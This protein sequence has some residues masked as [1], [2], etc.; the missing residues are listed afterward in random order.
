[1]VPGYILLTGAP[2]GKFLL[3]LKSSANSRF[4]EWG[5]AEAASKPV[6][7]GTKPERP[8]SVLG[9]RRHTCGSTCY[10]MG[11]KDGVQ[12][13]GYLKVFETKDLPG[14]P[15]LSPGHGHL[16]S[17]WYCLAE[18][19]VVIVY[20]S[21]T[22]FPP[23]VCIFV[24]TGAQACGCMSLHRHID[25]SK[26][27]QVDWSV[28]TRDLSLPSEPWDCKCLLLCLAFCICVLE[29]KSGPVLARYALCWPC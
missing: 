11:V 18:A 24:V 21:A 22:S 16:H 1:M 15:F 2:T 28:R 12:M 27:G 29:S 19:L 8:L 23:V 4:P 5:G 25:A 10:Q 7:W 14:R 13:I 26:P 17:V 3:P 9:Q 20:L 6:A